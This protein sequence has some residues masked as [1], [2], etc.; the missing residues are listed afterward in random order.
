MDFRASKLYLNGVRVNQL[1]VVGVAVERFW[2][3]AFHERRGVSNLVWNDVTKVE[4]R[5]ARRTKD[6]PRRCVEVGLSRE[7]ST[8]ALRVAQEVINLLENNG[9]RILDAIAKQMDGDGDAV[10]E[11]DLI[12]ERRQP[13]RIPGKT[14]VEVKLRRVTTAQLLPQV[15]RQVQQESWKLW[16]A[17]TAGS[18]GKF[19][20]RVCVLL[21]W[22]PG[23]PF[24]LGDWRD[25]FAEALPADA[26]SN[27]AE[28]WSVLWGWSQSSGD[29]RTK[30]NTKKAKTQAKAQAKAKSKAKAEGKQA[31]ERVFAKCRKAGRGHAKH[32]RSVSDLLKEIGTERSK[33]MQPTIGE[34]M[35]VWAKRFKW[36]D[37]SW[38]Q[39]AKCGSSSGG[40]SAGYVASYDALHDIFKSAI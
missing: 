4:L 36:S 5:N 6:G 22:G 1:T 26:S 20:E 19:S 23:D 29:A 3:L 33:K 21:R 28:N 25:S 30:A 40:G 37:D 16:P 18:K 17:A 24:A 12:C 34:R 13:L 27:A 38:G 9:Y 32:L 10:G 7:D 31:F 35:P 14:S 11:H 2:W 8:L 39:D 15:R